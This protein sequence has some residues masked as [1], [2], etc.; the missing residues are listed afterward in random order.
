MVLLKVV[1]FVFPLFPDLSKNPGWK[2]Q[3]ANQ[4]QQIKNI[5]WDLRKMSQGGSTWNSPNETPR[6]LWKHLKA[7]TQSVEGFLQTRFTKEQKVT[8]VRHLA[9]LPMISP[10]SRLLGLAELEVHELPEPLPAL[11]SWWGHPELFQVSQTSP[12]RDCGLPPVLPAAPGTWLLCPDTKQGAEA[13]PGF[14]WM[15][16]QWEC[17]DF[18]KV[19]L[20]SCKP[21][22][23]TRSKSIA[24]EEQEQSVTLEGQK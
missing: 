4:G 21:L 12:P 20:L 9:E 6:A 1:R 16:I 2:S 14:N 8:L 15:W 11:S 18:S 19:W 23:V 22:C 3:A 5:K 13:F 7:V 17:S 10:H 24:E